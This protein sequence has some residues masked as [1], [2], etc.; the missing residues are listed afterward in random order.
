MKTIKQTINIDGR[1][2]PII[3]M[4]PKHPKG[5]LPCVLWI[6]GGGY[7]TGMA[8]M[9]YFNRGGDI[10]KN[11]DAV[12]VSPEYRLAPKHPYPAA[13]HDC[14]ATLLYIKDNA[15][16]LGI[17]ANKIIVG[18]ESAGGGLAVATCMLARDKGEVKVYYQLPIYPMLDC[19]P[20]ES[21]RDNHSLGWNTKHNN[22]CW[23]LYLSSLDPTQPVPPYASPSR[24]T[25]YSNLPP[26]Y[27]FVCDGEPFYSETLTYV[28][29][30]NKAGIRASVDVYHANIHSFEMLCPWLN[31]SKQAKEKFIDV[32][33][34]ICQPID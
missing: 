21:N 17:D 28:E 22:Y 20:T 15:Q 18:G 3:I 2:I 1:S 24:Q 5:N 27:T 32:V 10:V 13:L 6:H 12:V 23:K 29:N 30:L 9:V 14:Y 16:Q 31:V 19:Q 25:D 7:V 4:Y 11:C 26:A 33:K 34:S 8:S